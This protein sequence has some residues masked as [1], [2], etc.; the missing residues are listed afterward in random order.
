MEPGKLFRIF[1]EAWAVWSHITVL[2]VLGSLHPYL[3]QI[4][5]YPDFVDFGVGAGGVCGLWSPIQW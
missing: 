2:H 3:A 4:L 1:L 5:I